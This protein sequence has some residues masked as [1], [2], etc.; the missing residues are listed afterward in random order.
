M[1]PVS[2]PSAAIR[3]PRAA[4]ALASPL[5]Q[6]IVDALVS[7]GAATIAAIAAS[8]ERRP[9]TLYFH[10]RA[11]ERA[12][13]VR[14]IGTHGSGRSAA[15]LFDVPARP[16]RLDYG[17]R[18]PQRAARLGPTLDSLL[19][20]ARRDVRRALSHA[21]TRA[22][23][24]ARELWVGRVRGRIGRGQLERVNALLAECFSIINT[25]RGGADAVPI[26]LAFALTPMRSTAA[27]ARSSS[28]DSSASTRRRR[29]S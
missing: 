24:E 25:A 20:L 16:M 8:L 18:P 27:R 5:R 29:K 9:D 6:E 10:L 19:R 28:S 26:A 7:G 4:R 3:S 22:E 21:H 15:A 1:M 17:G 2:A 12:G 14:R 11:L 13:L 23:G